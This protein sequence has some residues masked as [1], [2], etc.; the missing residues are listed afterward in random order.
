VPGGI[1][2]AFI[3]NGTSHWALTPPEMNGAYHEGAQLV[4]FSFFYYFFH[5]KKLFFSNTF[6]SQNKKESFK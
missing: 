2:L 1:I 4:P 6:E 5:L 3:E